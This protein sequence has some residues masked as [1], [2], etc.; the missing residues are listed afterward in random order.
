VRKYEWE[1]L[2]YIGVVASVGFWFLFGKWFI[3]LF[4]K[5]KRNG[6]FTNDRKLDILFW[7][8]FA[9]L[10]FSFGLPFILGLEKVRNSIGFLSQLRGVARFSWLFFY[11]MNIFVWIKIYD[12]FSRIKNRKQGFVFIFILL[13]ILAFEAYDYSKGSTGYLN[14]EIPQLA[15]QKN[16]MEEN[17]WVNRIDVR[18]FQAIMPLPYFHIGSESSWIEAKCNIDK[19]MYIASLKSGLPCNGVMM[20][21]TSLSQTYKNIELSLTPWEKYRVIDEYPNNKPLLLMVAKCDELS[22]DEKRLVEN[23]SF[24][25]ATPNFDLYEMSID[26]LRAIPAKVNFPQHYQDLIDSVENQINIGEKDCFLDK[27]GNMMADDKNLKGVKVTRKFTRIMEAPVM[28]DSTK[29]YYLRFWVKDY[30]KDMVVRTQILIIQ[31]TPDHQTL[32]EKYSDIFRHIRSFNGDWA[33]IEIPIKVKQPNE[34]FKLLIKNS[35]LDGQVVYFDEFSIW[36]EK[37]L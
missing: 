21:R 20:G 24:I 11:V 7:A 29:T 8:S 23:A 22:I 2:A 12:Y 30:A 25:M 13:G 14:N 6:S 34:I 28:L 18:E 16:Q 35:V 27:N 5:L 10:L 17:Q 1:S 33:L 37:L 26:S 3:N 4:Q 15:D 36:C 31:S 19:Q 32:E 9:L